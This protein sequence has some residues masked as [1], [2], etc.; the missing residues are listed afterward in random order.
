MVT[1]LKKKVDLICVIMQRVGNDM[2]DRILLD[3]EDVDDNIRARKEI[4]ELDLN[5]VDL[6]VGGEFVEMPKRTI[7]DFELTGLS[8]FDYFSSKYYLKDD[9]HEFGK[10]IVKELVDDANGPEIKKGWE[11]EMCDVV[12]N[13]PA[14]DALD[15]IDQRDRNRQTQRFLSNKNN[16]DTQEYKDALPSYQ[17]FFDRL[18]AE[19]PECLIEIK[20]QSCGGNSFTIAH[21]KSVNEVVNVCDFNSTYFFERGDETW[22]EAIN[23]EIELMKGKI[24]EDNT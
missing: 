16:V 19:F 20:L 14:I 18:R 22:D 1:R 10:S 2:S 13:C 4:N 9:K 6:Y 15:C 7:E 8:N 17:S 21:F 5:K 11:G 24:D 3:I 23:R 12:V